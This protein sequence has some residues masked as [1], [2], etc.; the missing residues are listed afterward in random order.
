MFS[1]DPSFESSSRSS[2][3]SGDDWRPHPSVKANGSPA[4]ENLSTRFSIGVVIPV[5]RGISSMEEEVTDN[6]TDI[7]NLLVTIQEVVTEKLKKTYVSQAHRRN[8]SYNQHSSSV[9]KMPKVPSVGNLSSC[10]KMNFSAYILQTDFD[11]NQQFHSLVRCILLLVET[12]RLF[13]ALKESNQALIS[14]ASAVAAWLELKDGRFFTADP[15]SPS[16]EKVSIK[17]GLKFLASL[18]SI[19]LPLRKQILEDPMNRSR[20]KSVRVVIVTGNPIVSQKLIFILAGLIG[21]DNYVIRASMEAATD[22]SSSTDDD[23]QTSTS[24]ETTRDVT[25]SDY[26]VSFSPT[27]VL[28]ISIERKLSSQRSSSD[29]STPSISPI[30]RSGSSLLARGWKVPTKSVPIA[31]SSP[32]VQGLSN[33]KAERVSIPLLHKETSYASL[34]NLSSSYGG[35]MQPQSALGLSSSWRGAFNFGS[36]MERWKMNNLASRGGFASTS[37]PRHDFGSIIDRTPSPATDYDEYPWKGSTPG[38]PLYKTL[39]RE[40]SST[41]SGGSTPTT[42]ETKFGSYGVG[43][44]GP[45]KLSSFNKLFHSYVAKRKFHVQRTATRLISSKVEQSKVIGNKI[46]AIMNADLNFTYT[47][48][49]DISVLSV[50]NEEAAPDDDAAP[51][52]LPPLVGYTEK[53]LPHFSLMSCIQPGNL[54]TS[55][56]ES[57][58]EDVRRM[59][60]GS[61]SDTYV[62]NLRQREVKLFEL[63]SPAQDEYP[64]PSM[65]T[66]FQRSTPNSKLTNDLQRFK[67]RPKVSLL[68]SPFLQGKSR[69]EQQ[70]SNGSTLSVTTS[71]VDAFDEKLNLISGLIN[72]FFCTQSKRIHPSGS[73]LYTAEDAKGNCADIDEDTCCDKIREL[74]RTLLG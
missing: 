11:L 68:F 45:S 5:G 51:Y 62:I 60:A 56:F 1:L 32:T 46:S 53:Y 61:V 43:I 70:L 21:Y 26:G 2:S 39:S 66:N 9:P 41:F 27:K 47:D 40:P 69:Y 55:I 38:T 10:K 14:W 18:F 63:R 16:S 12:P 13:V 65:S 19:L 54:E 42:S 57:M 74:I 67:L 52:K 49:G 7:S 6:W 4:Y 36:F 30:G 20:N 25:A 17:P 71:A 28:P 8:C 3:T 58:S 37:P 64:Q 15:T 24:D 22:D 33:V 23:T 72:R 73:A 34:Q 35:G 31:S 29:S 44:S 59:D 50:E 48:R